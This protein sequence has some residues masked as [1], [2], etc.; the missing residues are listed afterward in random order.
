MKIISTL[1]VMSVLTA[2]AQAQLTFFQWSVASGG[3]GHSY[4]L[5]PSGM[6]WVQAEAFAV[7]QGGHLASITSTAEQTFLNATFL[8]GA[9]ATKPFWIGLTDQAVEGTF[10]WTTGEP[11][12]FTNWEPTQPDN[13][14]GADNYAAMN[15]AFAAG[16]GGA[17]QGG[18]DDL[19]NVGFNEGGLTPPPYRGIVEVVQEP[20]SD[21]LASI[22]FSAVDICWPGRTNKMYQVQYR[23]NLSGTNWFDF[24]SPVLG[25]A[26]NCVTDGINGMEQRFYRVTRV[27]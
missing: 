12:T 1:I 21:L 18:W 4:A 16:R 26:T 8:T 10:V 3:N 15:F 27:P 11:F 7:S 17:V 23:T 20:S 14:T 22:H 19:P 9:E 5:T 13:F 25:T 24:G 2:S 6:D